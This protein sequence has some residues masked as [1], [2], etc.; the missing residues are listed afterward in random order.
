M[1]P[2]WIQR[3]E[4]IAIRILRERNFVLCTRNG[5]VADVFQPGELAA[6]F[7]KEYAASQTASPEPKWVCDGCRAEYAEYINGCP[8]C[9]DK[10]LHFSVRQKAEQP[11]GPEQGVDF[12]RS[13]LARRIIDASRKAGQPPNGDEKQTTARERAGR[14]LLSR[15][16][17]MGEKIDAGIVQDYLEDAEQRI[18][19]LERERDEA[20]TQLL[21]Q[22]GECH[23]IRRAYLHE[24]WSKEAAE[25]EVAK[26]GAQVL[27]DAANDLESKHLGGVLQKWLRDR[28][29]KLDQP[30]AP[31]Q[32]GRT[33]AEVAKE[34]GA[35]LAKANFTNW[36][37][38]HSKDCNLSNGKSPCN[39]DPILADWP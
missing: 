7:A 26:L 9:S 6:V 38:E 33:F 27:R 22:Q 8:K 17:I 10:G 39:C 35:T 30:A 32:L 23:T 28:A 13:P 15:G 18:S 19:D 12:T 34:H 21:N 31:E 1:T 3:A 25:A 20:H 14:F 24:K 11:A 2:E 4:G 5:E 36:Q 16:H 29:D 37:G